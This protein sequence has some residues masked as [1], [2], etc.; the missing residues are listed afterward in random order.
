MWSF[1]ICLAGIGDNV[2][3]TLLV[4]LKSTFKT[5]HVTTDNKGKDLCSSRKLTNRSEHIFYKI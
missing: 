3:E 1:L 5:K 4:P 2:I